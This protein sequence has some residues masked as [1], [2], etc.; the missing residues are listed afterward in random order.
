MK[1]KPLRISRSTGWGREGGSNEFARLGAVRTPARTTATR[2]EAT[3]LS[4]MRSR[5]SSPITMTRR[6]LFSAQR[7]K[8][9]HRRT[10]ALGPTMFPPTAH[11]GI[12]ILNVVYER[13]PGKSRNEGTHQTLEGRISH[14]KH[15]VRTNYK[16]ADCGEGGIAKV[17]GNATAHLK[18]GIGGAADAF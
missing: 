14:A 17:V 9:S 8:R 5:M 15:H 10:P 2:A 13:T 1:R 16:S 7:C 12:Q 11:L 3:P 18:P 6:A 4:M